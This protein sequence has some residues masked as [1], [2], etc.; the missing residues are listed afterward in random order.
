MAKILKLLL[1]RQYDCQ[2]PTAVTLFS[3]LI[4]LFIYHINFRNY[5]DVLSLSQGWIK[6]GSDTLLQ[7]FD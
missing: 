7:K 2:C 3:F 1:D 4:K 6:F 5:L